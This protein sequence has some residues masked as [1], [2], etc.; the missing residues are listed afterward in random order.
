MTTR[1]GHLAGAILL[2]T[3]FAWLGVRSSLAMAGSELPAGAHAVSL[4]QWWYAALA[5][6]AIIGLL[7]RHQGTRLVL[8]AWAAIFT[9][10]NALTPV[11]LGGKGIGLAV[12]GGAIGLA[13]ALGILYLAFRSLEP[14][15]GSA[16]P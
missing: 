3:F 12:A 16:A 11:Y 1:T 5:M 14:P 7:L 9:T 13:I 6:L 15:A 2:L 4:L 10:R 8:F